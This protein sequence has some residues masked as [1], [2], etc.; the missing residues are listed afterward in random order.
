LAKALTIDPDVLRRLR[1][2]PRAEKVECLSAL[3]ELVESFG[4][5]HVH[6]GLGIRKLGDR[7]FECRG[8]LALRFIFE[9][10]QTDLFVAF[11]G[12]H[13]DIKSLLRSGKYR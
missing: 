3:C 4:Q 10:R 2:L 6:S 7:L 9:D 12:N 11:L 5:P 1:R 8:S 13:D